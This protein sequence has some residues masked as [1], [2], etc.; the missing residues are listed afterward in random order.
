MIGQAKHR[1]KF[2]S[3]EELDSEGSWAISYG[4]MI[5]LL[6]TFFI[7]F[8]NVS[9]K[10]QEETKK[11]QAAL[12]TKLGE[13]PGNSVES[14]K[15]EPV[16]DIGPIEKTSGI[17]TKAMESWGGKPHTIGNRIVIE[18]PEISFFGFG[19]T[20]VT[21]EGAKV[22]K[23]FIHL[24]LPYAGKNILS[25]RA[26]TDHVKVD[27]EKSK[28]L[29]RKYEDSLELSAMRAISTMRVLQKNGL[30]LDR[31]RISGHG[32]LERIIASQGSNPLAPNTKGNPLARKIVLMVEPVTQEKY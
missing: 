26:F 32:E 8:F 9:Q 18:F 24:Y 21:Q 10:S 13:K 6:L 15:E 31:M 25:I 22:I 19:E 30:P 27:K 11:V 29:G 4:D 17:E 5:T 1:R 14:G 7:L 16:V 3:E 23:R 12:I 20:H 2:E 28:L